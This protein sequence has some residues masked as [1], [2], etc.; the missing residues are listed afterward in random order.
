MVENHEMGTTCNQGDF[1]HKNTKRID[2]W[3]DPPSNE[4]VGMGY[5]TYNL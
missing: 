1:H 3:D 4:R 5:P 2:P